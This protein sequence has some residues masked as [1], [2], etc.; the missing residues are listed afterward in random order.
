[1]WLE[2]WMVT[3]PGT[4]NA[5]C[6]TLP[7]FSDQKG[8]GSTGAFKAKKINDML[9]KWQNPEISQS[10]RDYNT[11]IIEGLTGLKLI[12]QKKETHGNAQI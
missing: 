2:S 10:Y 11:R 4:I 9:V 7:H 12:S 1:M 3:H 8:T 5:H 6:S